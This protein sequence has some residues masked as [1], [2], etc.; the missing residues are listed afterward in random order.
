MSHPFLPKEESDI[1]K[2]LKTLLESRLD[3]GFDHHTKDGDGTRVDHREYAG[4][5][6]SRT[7]DN[8]ECIDVGSDE[9]IGLS[10]KVEHSGDA[11]NSPHGASRVSAVANNLNE[12]SS[13][14]DREQQEG[15][16]DFS[17]FECGIRKVAEYDIS[18]PTRRQKR[19]DHHNS[20][21]LSDGSM[22]F[23]DT[24][25]DCLKVV[26]SDFKI[27]D[28][29]VLDTKPYD[30]AVTDGDMIV[31]AVGKSVCLFKVDTVN[32]KVRLR[33]E[34]SF[35]TRDTV[36]SL[37][38]VGENI[39]VLFSDEKGI[40]DETYIEIRTKNGK[41]MRSMEYFQ[42]KR[43]PDI[44][45]VEPYSIRCR[46]P[47]ELIVNEPKQLRVFG[48]NGNLRWFYKHSGSNIESI[49]FDNKKNIYI[50]D[51]FAKSI[52]QVSASS[53]R[54]HRVIIANTGIRNPRCVL[55][56]SKTRTLVVGFENNN[57]VQVYKFV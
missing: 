25:N 15:D 49:S 8:D 50:C 48:L 40:T 14:T 37:C 12:A 41:I 4:Q 56:N 21:L 16:Q 2:S 22:A 57:L 29:I 23:I 20:V 32:G 35:L 7:R 9:C 55:I 28:L 53:Y 10:D 45:L 42:N 34:K 47:D 6:K 18:L 36:Y 46:Y 3:K 31:V 51:K 24:S 27:L 13:E 30:L 33:K 5:S 17:F 38:T 1:L 11:V 43:G 26:S 54:N 52:Y 19:C 44:D 39:G